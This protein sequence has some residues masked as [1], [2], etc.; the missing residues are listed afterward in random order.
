MRKQKAPAMKKHITGITVTFNDGSQ[1]QIPQETVSSLER[2]INYYYCYAFGEF[3]GAGLINYVLK[4]F[5]EQ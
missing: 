5:I 1:E 4:S 2:T 3:D